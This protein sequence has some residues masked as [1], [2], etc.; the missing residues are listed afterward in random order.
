MKASEFDAVLK[1]LES[2]IARLRS[3][4]EQYFQ[5]LERVPPVRMRERLDRQVRQL[6]RNQPQNTAMR[7]KYQTIFQRW[8]TFTQYWDRICRRIEEGTYRRDLQR[9]Q[10]R[11]ARVERPPVEDEG[12]KSVDV[13]LDL[14]M[15]L[16]KEIS[17]ALAALSPKPAAPT[18]AA[19]PLSLPDMDLDPH[20]APVQPKPAAPRP[21][22]PPVPVPVPTAAPRPAPP[23][24]PAPG[25]RRPAPPPPPP[26]RAPRPPGPPAAAASLRDEDVRRIYGRYVEAR[27]QAGKR[28][29]GVSYEKLASQ[30]RKMEPE[31]RRKHA[32]KSIDFEVV[33]KDGRVGL[34][35]VARG[36][37]GKK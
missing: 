36:K 2:E 14:D 22:T 37:P 29:D 19:G 18:P 24:P 34:K 5:G 12:P 26:P 8:I 13:E 1:D 33:V 32:G 10:R 6:R 15:D 17:D 7:F 16:D 23:K 27:K 30:I 31:L 28:P 35:P 25:P 20:P 4:Y 11:R 3:L 9:V 21:P